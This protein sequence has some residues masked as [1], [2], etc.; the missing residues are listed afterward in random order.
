LAL[1]PADGGVAIAGA[2]LLDLVDLEVEEAI[3]KLKKHTQ[4]YCFC[5]V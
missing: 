1:G 2:L 3:A 5:W 4:R